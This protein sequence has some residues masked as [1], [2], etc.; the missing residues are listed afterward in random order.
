M[1]NTLYSPNKNPK[2]SIKNTGF[3]DKQKALDTLEAIKKLKGVKFNLIGNEKTQIGFIAD[4]IENI[5]P[6]IVTKDKNGEIEGLEYSRL[7]ALL[8]EAVKELSEK[9]DNLKK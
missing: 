2:K 5:L 9:V 6:E 3:K 1:T 4:D 8:V 7:T